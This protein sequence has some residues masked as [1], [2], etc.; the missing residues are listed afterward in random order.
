M[1][2]NVL[3][4]VLCACGVMACSKPAPPI[5]A[6]TAKIVF[7]PCAGSDHAGVQSR[8]G[9]FYPDPQHP[10]IYVGFAVVSPVITQPLGAPVLYLSGGPGEGGNSLGLSLESW[11]YQ[12]LDDQWQRPIVLWDS[13]GNEGAWGAF[14]CEAYR[15]FSVR[16]LAATQAEPEEELRLAQSCLA[17]WQVLLTNT[18]LEQF[19][20]QQSARDALALMK[21]LGFNQWHVMS[22]SY[23]SRVAE[24]LQF[25]APKAVQSLLLDSPYSWQLLNRGLHA[26]QWAAAMTHF[27]TFCQ[28]SAQCQQGAEDIHALFWQV[29]AMLDA[30]PIHLSF[31][32]DGYKERALIA[33]P[34]FA[35]L[36]F[37]ELYSAANYPQ[38]VVQLKALA[39]GD[40]APFATA[41]SS[42]LAA[43]LRAEA[44]PWLYWVTECNDNQT[45]TTEDYARAVN[46]L[47]PWARFLGPDMS[48]TLCQWAPIRAQAQPPGA[49]PWVPT[50]VLAGELDPVASA[51]ASRRMAQQ[52]Q[53][54]YLVAPFVGHG[55]LSQDVCTTE[56]LETF[57]QDAAGFIANRARDGH[58][59][60]RCQPFYFHKPT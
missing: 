41:V 60:G 43:S 56:W 14:N 40:T 30:K 55:L 5:A 49:S 32:L 44:S 10:A 26:E 4:W 27:F 38:M 33:A 51:A 23:G 31:E 16:Q 48:L 17:R 29:I 45:Q 37:S 35:H 34:Q 57:W 46:Q 25:L 2:V 36:F 52:R 50:V 53:G 9:R 21:A 39:A 3:L 22:V 20:A 15:Q 28:H 8:C 6:T 12:L 1:R 11:R 54:V 13:R 47:E 58:N 7:S 42:L 59:F 19:S 18:G 24:W